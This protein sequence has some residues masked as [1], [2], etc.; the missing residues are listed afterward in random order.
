MIVGQQIKFTGVT[1]SGL[2]DSSLYYINTVPTGTTLTVSLI[3]N[4]GIP[5][6]VETATFTEK[7][8][9]C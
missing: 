7:G 9:I 8:S 1:T 4:S 2:D 3:A 6:V 5:V